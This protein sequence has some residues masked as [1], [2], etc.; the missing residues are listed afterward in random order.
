MGHF[1]SFC[2][3]KNYKYVTESTKTKR[4]KAIHLHATQ[5]V[6]SAAV[7]KWD[8]FDYRSVLGLEQRDSMVVTTL[9]SSSPH[10]AHYI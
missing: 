9:Y 10:F 7:W 6:G 4:A 3:S 8:L 1:P 2:L 5:T